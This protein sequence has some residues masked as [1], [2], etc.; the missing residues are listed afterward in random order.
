MPPILLRPEVSQWGPKLKPL[1]YH[2]YALLLAGPA[3][4][5]SN[6]FGEAYFAADF[7]WEQDLPAF[8]Y[9]SNHITNRYLQGL[10]F[11]LQVL[12]DDVTRTRKI[13]DLAASRTALQTL[14]FCNRQE[15]RPLNCGA[16]CARTKA[17]FAVMLGYLPDIFY[18]KSLGPELL[19]P[20]DF[21]DGGERAFLIDL[22][23]HARDRGAIS[24]VPGLEERFQECVGWTAK[25]YPQKDKGRGKNRLGGSRASHLH[26]LKKLVSRRRSGR[27]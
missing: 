8:P 7:S 19:L 1:K 13:A 6:L 17:M 26:S 16:K 11:R 3:F 9:D 27:A 25:L 22:Y 2:S 12:G 5:L 24:A 23:Q 4:L 10:S 15:H 20:I 14:S 18:D 21:S